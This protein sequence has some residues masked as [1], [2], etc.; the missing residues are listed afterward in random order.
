MAG[1]SSLNKKVVENAFLEFRNK[2]MHDE[3]IKQLN[4]ICQNLLISAIHYRLR[5]SHAEGH[6]FTGNLINSIV[7]VLYQDEEIADV[8]TAGE[9]GQIRKPICR[10]MTARKKAYYYSNDYS[11]TQS[12]YRAEVPTNRGVADEDIQAFL[13]SN[14]PSVKDGFC[15]TV[16]YTV[17][18]A[19]WVEMERGTTGY[20]K[21]LHNARKEFQ[22]SFKLL[23]A[24]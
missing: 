19:E 21:T 8:W 3:I 2:T 14:T 18:Y 23:K 10:K 7:V 11:N 4:V 24:S 20:L 5:L 22:R 15:V 12:K 9:H 6:D 13:N 1:I 16:A 17:E